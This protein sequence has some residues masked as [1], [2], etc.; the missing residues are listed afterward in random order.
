MAER[1]FLATRDLVFR[2]KLAAVVRAAGGDV[3]ADE[4]GCDIAVLDVE[5]AA[6]ADRIR[7]WTVKRIRVLAYGS[8]VRPDLLRAAR[9]AGAGAGPDSG[10]VGRRRWRVGAGRARPSAPRWAPSRGR[11]ATR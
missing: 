10:G 5:G 11:R 7:A 1:V 4:A 3:T 2:S 6:V 8:H 9:G